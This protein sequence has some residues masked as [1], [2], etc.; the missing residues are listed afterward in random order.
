MALS[1]SISFPGPFTV[2]APTNLAFEKIPSADL[3]VINMIIGECDFK[4][5]SSNQSYRAPVQ[6]TQFKKAFRLSLLEDQ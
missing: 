2:F 3:Q 6:I 1:L 5:S 4:A